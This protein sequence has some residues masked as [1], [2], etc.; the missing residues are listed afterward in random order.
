MTEG[1]PGGRGSR[2]GETGRWRLAA[3]VTLALALLASAVAVV[4]V[5][6]TLSAETQRSELDAQTYR[7]LEIRSRLAWTHYDLLLDGLHAAVGGAEP[8]GERLAAFRLERDTALDELRELATLPSSTGAAAMELLDHYDGE[9]FE[10]W[11]YEAT[12]LDDQ[13]YVSVDETIAGQV[14]ALDP[15]LSD[16]M[17]AA[18]L[19]RLIAADALVIELSKQPGGSPP[20]AAEYSD[21]TLSIV[22][23]TPG[24]VGPDR[25]RPVIDSVVVRDPDS[26]VTALIDGVAVEE[27]GLVWDYDQWLVAAAP[28]DFATDP[29]ASIDELYRAAAT[30]AAELEAPVLGGIADGERAALDGDRTS[31]VMALY[32]GAA[33]LFLGALLVAVG[34][35][36]RLRRG[37]QRMALAAS[38][39][40]LTGVWNRRYLEEEIAGRCQRRGYHHVVAMIDLDRFKLINDTYGHNVGDQL[41]VEVA[42]RLTAV[43]AEVTGEHEHA[44]GEVV[45]QG[46]DEF[47]VAFHSPDRLDVGLVTRRLREMTGPVDFGLEEPVQLE[48]SVGVAEAFAPSEIADLAEA[49][50]LATYEDKRA[51]SGATPSP[52]RP[53]TGDLELDLT[54]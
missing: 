39:D 28:V 31:V 49:A 46:G 5:G 18:M 12:A 1:S 13:H 53:A 9:P 30:A 33:V 23:S 41:L 27:L 47:I 54:Q 2:S 4:V 38:T 10:S 52:S 8:S 36:L 16:G 29:P 34:L 50:D 22:S 6:R 48:F 24:W 7:L 26:P 42:A 11:P 45:R 40:P 43:A 17:R 20:W 15:A 19:P 35:V 44:S 21:Y 32:G 25:D 14:L 51:R 3:G 37:H